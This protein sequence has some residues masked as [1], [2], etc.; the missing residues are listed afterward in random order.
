MFKPQYSFNAY[1]GGLTLKFEYILDF[2][3]PALPLPVIS[4]FR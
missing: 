1:S 3:T 2:I 4:Y